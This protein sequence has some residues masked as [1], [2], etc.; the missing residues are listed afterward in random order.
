MDHSQTR[1]L[2]SRKMR[3]FRVRNALRGSD[4][5]PRLSVSKT[6]T[7]LF[8]QL[9]NDEKGVTIGGIGTLSKQNKKTQFNRKSKEAARHL[10]GQIAEIA[11]K[12]Q[13]ERV[14]FDRGPN[15]YHG[16]IA[17]LADAARSAGLQF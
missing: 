11:K 7:H 15:K 13:I 12:N 8:V 4:T 2:N 14:V 16:V 10:G 6:N 17:E 3:A 9:I 5:R 1:R